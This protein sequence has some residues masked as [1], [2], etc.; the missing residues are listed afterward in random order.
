MND[1]ISACEKLKLIRQLKN[2][3]N[4]KRKNFDMPSSHTI[5]ITP[6]YLLGL[7][8]GEGCFSIVG[9]KRIGVSCTISLT[10]SQAPLLNAIKNFLD[11]Y[12]PDDIHL[13]TSPQYLEI[14]SQRTSMYYRK[15]V[16]N[17]KPM[18]EVQVRQTNI[19]VDTFIPML[20]NLSFITRK[21]KDF[22]D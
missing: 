5:R 1:S 9:G 15:K 11:S 22:L 13:K 8:E 3:M 2:S 7:I 14:I 19:I 18:I 12:S 6:Y 21:H 16:T 4:T 17:S 10:S 20:A